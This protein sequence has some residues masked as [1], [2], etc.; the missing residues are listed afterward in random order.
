MMRELIDPVLEK[1][2]RDRDMI[3]KLEQDDVKLVDRIHQL[4]TAVYKLKEDGGKTKFDEIAEDILAV[5]IKQRELKE[6]LTDRIDNFIQ[7][8]E[9]YNFEID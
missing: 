4:E 2:K 9:A 1:G 8:T 3:L 6:T 5:E 7:K